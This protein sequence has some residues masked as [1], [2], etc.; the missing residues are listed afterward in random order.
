MTQVQP[1]AV[2]PRIG[3]NAH[4]PPLDGLRDVAILGVLLFHCGQMTGGFLEKI[5]FLVRWRCRTV[6]MH[7]SVAAVGWVLGV[8]NVVLAMSYLVEVL[9]AV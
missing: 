5:Q 2:L 6:G 8:F 3:R 7:D 1:A 9:L 4:L